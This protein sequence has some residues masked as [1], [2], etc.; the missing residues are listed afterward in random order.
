VEEQ[1]NVGLLIAIIVVVGMS[2]LAAVTSAEEAATALVSPGRVQRLVEAEQPGSASLETL[3]EQAFRFRAAAALVSAVAYCVSATAGMWA[4]VGLATDVPMWVVGAAAAG[5]AVIVVYSLGHALPR[6]VAVQN[7]EGVA[8]TFAAASLQITRLFYPFSRGLSA[9]WRWAVRLI[10]GRPDAIPPWVTEDEY[11]IHT[12]DS[13]D[14][15]RDAFEEV[16]F[17]SISDFT[18]KVVREVMI[19]R[20]DMTCLP[21]TATASEAI[22]VIDEAGYSRLPVYHE[23]LDDIRGVLYAKDLLA[24]VV[25]D[26]GVRPSHIARRAYFVP[27]TKPVRE[28]LFEMRAK[29]HIAIVADEYGGTAG[30]VTIEDLLEEIVGEIFDEYDSAIPLVVRLDNTRY[31][32][33][34]RIPVDDVNERFGTAIAMDADTL[35]G[36]VSELAGRIPVE[37][38]A[39]E[40]EGL[41]IIVDELEG[42]RVRQLVVEPSVSNGT[43]EGRDA[44]SHS[45]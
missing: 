36:V 17:D 3:A 10:A 21:D 37:G 2:L 12:T 1:H 44:Q 25:G 33:D 39:V 35:G 29:T 45:G 8:L 13:E 18:E 5:V 23:T 43:E 31:R 7:P 11:R 4:A 28:L 27:E 6:T 20:T 16:L 34:A 41:R 22:E 14:P 38:D 30:L 24:A 9:L 42:N 32:V 15:E 19:P 40:I 26:E